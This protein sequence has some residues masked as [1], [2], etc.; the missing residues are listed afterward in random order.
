M[1]ND[2]KTIE[3]NELP[4]YSAIKKLASALWKQD[5]AYHGAAIM[6]GAG[7]SR[8]AST[9]GDIN[10][11]LPIWNDLSSVLAKDLNS[12]NNSDPLRLAEEYYAYFGKQALHDL[13]K[14][15]VNDVAWTP[16]EM[17]KNLLELPW[18]EV[19]TTNWDTLLERAALE[20]HQP[21]YSL[22]SRQEDLASAH[23]PRI[24]KLHGTIGI[25]TNLIFTQEDYRKYPQK[26]A[27]FVNFARQV[28]IENELC[29]LGFSGD[30]PNFLQWAGWVRDNLTLHARRIYLAGALNLTA[31]KRKY[32]ES[33]NITPIDLWDSISDFDDHDARHSKATEKFLQALSNLKPKQAWE[34]TPT[35]LNRSKLTTEELDKTTKNH[36]YAS[37]L[38]ERQI[39]ILKTDR[40]SYPG[41]LVC[42]T[43][44]RWQL[45]TQLND[46]SPNPQNLSQL[47]PDSRAKLLYEIAWRHNVTYEVIPQWLSKEFLKICDPNNPC[48]L[49][50]KKQMEISL[51]LLKNIRWID[52]NKNEAKSIEKKLITILEK[53]SQ[54]WPACLNELAFHQA[55]VARDRFDYPAIEENIEKISED[56]PVWRLRK[57]SLLAELGRYDE[58]EILIKKAYRELLTQYRNDRSSIYIFSRLAWAHYLIRGAQMFKSNKPFKVFPSYYKE[59]KCDPFAQ[60]EDIQEKI[61]KA[62]EKQQKN[63]EIE[64][65]FEPGRYRDNSKSVSFNNTLHPI[66]IFEGVSSNAGVPLRWDHVSFLL[67]LSSGL[68]TLDGVEDLYHFSLAIRTANSDT[69]DALKKVF[70]RIKVACLP[71]EDANHLLNQ[72]IKAIEYWTKKRTTGI[73]T[74]QGHAIDRLRVFIEVLARLLIRTTADKAKAAFRMAMDLG[75]EKSLYH[76]WLFDSL[77]NLINYSLKSIP[78]FQHSELLLDALQFPLQPE[79]GL[80]DSDRWPNPIIENPGKRN[81]DT[82]LDRRID[83]IID[84]IE[85]CSIKST[86]ALLRLLPLIE[87]DFLKPTEKQKIAEKIWGSQPNYE[88]LPNTGLFK[89][90]LLKLPSQDI[91]KARTLVRK[92][93]FEVT[94]E[95]LID[96]TL[97]E[98]IANA[99]ISQKIKEL[100]DEIQAVNY[101]NRLITWRMPNY[102]K[103]V[104]GFRDQAERRKCELIGQVLGQSICPSLPPKALIEKNFDKLYSFYSEVDSPSSVMG[105][106]YFAQINDILATKVG[107]I[108]G[109]GLQDQN[110]SK[111]AYSAYAL[112]K[113]REITST[114]TITKLISRLIYLIESGRTV[115]LSELLWTANQMCNKDYLF[116]EE[117]AV[118]ID[119]I[120]TIFDNTKYKFISPVSRDAVSVSFIRVACVRLAR[121]ILGRIQE[122]NSELVRVLEEARQDQLPEVRFAEIKPEK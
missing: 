117:L 60:L 8:C 3:V 34:W 24:V 70:S 73:Q 10:K 68:I 59:S 90:A 23:A 106:V 2:S 22:V 114:E 105:F 11:K 107:R 76:F 85:P 5:T 103:D 110:S 12:N 81:S 67:D 36:S 17:Y 18:S 14:K 45:Q 64:P 28:F 54:Y 86:P 39:S 116:E 84:Q 66:L 69:S 4:D 47:V 74:Q 82:L 56:E 77:S 63:Q 50:K 87:G 55:I 48:I 58:G 31:A 27:A 115:G 16:G 15:E 37:S 21:I 53:N 100:P 44:V 91:N 61:S 51:L 89:Y 113:W 41:W 52:Q 65:L 49:S 30:D 38:L 93:L 25:T 104:F 6:L 40:K 111:V 96:A 109:K 108:I 95:N 78:D 35:Q 29:L 13:I 20:V 120:P 119:S 112:L 80:E 9:S 19:L 75:K 32:L 98:D 94:D 42:P 71:E 1:R 97:M 101:F 83:E 118:L 57:A 43:S 79:I 99:A 46:P 26:N 62:Y 7:F 102:D 121:D 92:S 33:I 72:C 122:K 88:T